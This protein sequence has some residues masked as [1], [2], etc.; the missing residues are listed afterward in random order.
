MV[1]HSVICTIVADISVQ[2]VYRFLLIT[3]NNGRALS[4]PL[5]FIRKAAFNLQ[6][7]NILVRVLLS[8]Y[9]ALN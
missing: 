4:K 7:E 2:N 8:V 9:P 3:D 5:L 6:E 1:S